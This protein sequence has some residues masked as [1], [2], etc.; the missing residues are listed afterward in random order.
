MQQKSSLGSFQ[1]F[2]FNQNFI[3]HENEHKFYRLSQLM[4]TCSFSKIHYITIRYV[5]PTIYLKVGSVPIYMH[6]ARSAEH[7]KMLNWML[8][9]AKVSKPGMR[10][11]HLKCTAEE[12][13]TQHRQGQGYTLRAPGRATQAG[14]QAI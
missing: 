5:K 1:S 4:L 10:G 2:F 6:A 12:A 14:V 9:H 11:I 3:L 7:S 8:N 13:Q